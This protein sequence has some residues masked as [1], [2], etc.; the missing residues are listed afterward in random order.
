MTQNGPQLTVW[1][2][3]SVTSCPHGSKGI[4]IL[5]SETTLSWKRAKGRLVAW[6][7]AL[8]EP[9]PSLAVVAAA[10][11]T[12]DQR[13]RSRR[14]GFGQVLRNVSHN[15]SSSARSLGEGFAV[16]SSVGTC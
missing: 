12:A 14:V 5:A 11:T 4:V 2:G 13:I 8:T 7:A 10:A 3:S 15:R 1:C 9:K 6:G 16:C